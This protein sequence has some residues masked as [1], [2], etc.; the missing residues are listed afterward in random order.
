MMIR[1]FTS[2]EIFGSNSF[3]LNLQIQ[4]IAFLG[5][6]FRFCIFSKDMHALNYQM[7]PKNTLEVL[8]WPLHQFLIFQIQIIHHHYHG[9]LKCADSNRQQ[10]FHLLLISKVLPLLGCRCFFNFRNFMMLKTFAFCA[11]FD[12]IR[13]HFHLLLLHYLCICN[14]INSVLLFRQPTCQYFASERKKVKIQ[15]GFFSPIGARFC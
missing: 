11:R 8:A 5:R 3:R 6:D 9:F 15:K 10:L 1:S 12:Y 7:L 4:I 13:S 14:S 2:L